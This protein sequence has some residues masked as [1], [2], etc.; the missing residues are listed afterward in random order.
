MW[1][2]KLREQIILKKLKIE[3]VIKTAGMSRAGFYHSLAAGS[4]RF[5]IVVKIIVKYKL[6]FYAL[7]DTPNPYIEAHVVN[8]EIKCTNLEEVNKLI[9]KQK[10][11]YEQKI[12]EY[13]EHNSHLKDQVVFLQKV[14]AKNMSINVPNT[15]KN[16]N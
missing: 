16:K 6:D 9:D 8:Q 1:T 11:F 5:E 12:E 10:D 14:V 2:E 4:L 7:I 3:D 13:K 15:K